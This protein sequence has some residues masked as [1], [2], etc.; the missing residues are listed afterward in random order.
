[1]LSSGT[2]CTSSSHGLATPLRLS[3]FFSTVSCCATLV[4]AI[5]RFS[6]AA[7]TSA[8]ARVTSIAGSVPNRTC[9][10]LSS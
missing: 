4:C 9:F 3:A 8:A 6:L 5:S 10:L 2:M 7:E 1:M